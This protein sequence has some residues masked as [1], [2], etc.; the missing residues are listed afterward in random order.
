MKVYIEW[1]ET[2]SMSMKVKRIDVV[3]ENGTEVYS[4]FLAVGLL[5]GLTMTVG[6]K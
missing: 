2:A 6:K 1:R 3:M 5:N 4:D